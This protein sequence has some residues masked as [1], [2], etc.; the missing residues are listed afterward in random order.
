MWLQIYIQ[1]WPGC[2]STVNIVDIYGL[3]DDVDVDVD[4]D[5]IVVVHACLRV[6]VSVCIYACVCAGQ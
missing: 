2:R 3:E 6:C 4:D 5:V 1:G